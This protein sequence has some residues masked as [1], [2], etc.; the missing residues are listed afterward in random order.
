[1]LIT[2]QTEFTLDEVKF[3]AKDGKAVY[4]TISSVYKTILEQQVLVSFYRDITQKV[5]T[6]SLLA[7]KEKSLKDAQ[8]E[9]KMGRCY[10]LQFPQWPGYTQ[11][12]DPDSGHRY[13]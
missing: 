7:R 6:Q 8:K 13:P 10:S 4:F 2:N 11:C 5:E 12:T 1:L 3:T 9:A